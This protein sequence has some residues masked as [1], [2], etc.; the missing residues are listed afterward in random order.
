[1]KKT[2]EEVLEIIKKELAIDELVYDQVGQWDSL[3]IITVL[4][5]LDVA[6]EE[7]LKDILELQTVKTPKEIVDVLAN[8]GLIS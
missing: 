7:G 5:A 2:K 4:M 8:H 3:D 6:Y 1:M